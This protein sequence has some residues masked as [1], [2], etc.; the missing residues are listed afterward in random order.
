MVDRRFILYMD[1]LG[2]RNLLNKEDLVTFIKYLTGNNRTFKHELMGPDKEGIYTLATLEPEI[3]NFSDHIVASY[4]SN[5]LIRPYTENHIKNDYIGSLIIIAAQ[6]YRSAL[7]R[8]LLIRGALTEGM[9]EHE[10]TSII[11]EA[12]IEAVDIEENIAI[13]PRVV[14]TEKLISLTKA[15]ID[16]RIIT[17]DFDGVYFLNFFLHPIVI[18]VP[19][20]QIML[21]QFEKIKKIIESNIILL[22]EDKNKNFRKLIKWYWLANNFDEA[23][24]YYQKENNEILKESLLKIKKFNI[25]GGY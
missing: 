7:E 15:P 25:R 10:G 21:E 23:L 8:G 2:A 18:G 6:I 19:S 22:E 24:N 12:L 9:L 16:Y 4:P 13:Y 17:R 11:G 1:V 20:P 14:I 3:S 5:K